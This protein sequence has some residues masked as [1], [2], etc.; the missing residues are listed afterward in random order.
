[1]TT[2]ALIAP[3]TAI[4]TG[5]A[6]GIGAAVARKLA[7]RSI[8]VLIADVQEGPGQALV[9]QLKAQYSVDAVYKHVD[10][11]N[12]SDVVAM[13]N[14]V[15]ERWG[16][17]DYAANVAAICQNASMNDQNMTTEVFDR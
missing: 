4:V 8:N 14:T 15:R 1:M 12:E 5:G 16:R 11:S 13:V 2:S 9:E 10:V 17:L 7:S 6:V 3:W